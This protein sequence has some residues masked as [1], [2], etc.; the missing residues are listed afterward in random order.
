M[1]VTVADADHF[2]PSG[3]VHPTSVAANNH[4]RKEDNIHQIVEYILIHKLQ[5]FRMS[6]D[7]GRRK[8]TSFLNQIN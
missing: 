3:A 8:S 1:I 4:L 2:S 5:L 6:S 7:N